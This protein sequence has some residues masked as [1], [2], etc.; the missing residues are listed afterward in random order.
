[1]FWSEQPSAVCNG[2]TLP[3]AGLTGGLTRGS[4]HVRDGGSLAGATA[5]ITGASSGIRYG[6]ASRLAADGAAVAIN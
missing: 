1:M 2:S 6:V 5:I 4:L 3:L